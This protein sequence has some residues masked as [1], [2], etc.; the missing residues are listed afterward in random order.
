[1]SHSKPSILIADDDE[2]VLSALTLALK[3]ENYQIIKATTPHQVITLLSRKQFSCLL[4]DLNYTQDTTSGSEGMQLVEAIRNIDSHVP[5]IAMTGYSSVDIAVEMMKRGA[6]DFIEKPWRNAQLSN[7]IKQQIERVNIVRKNEK[8]SQANALLTNKQRGVIAHS[9]EMRQVLAQ[10]ERIAVS[11]M[12]VLFTGENGTGKSM[13]AHYL[14][15]HSTRNNNS[16]ITVNMGAISEPLF[17]SEMFGHVKGAFT[18]AKE[19]RIGRFELASQGTLFLD[20]IANIHLN[21]QAKLLHILE[22]RK[23][24]RVG[25]HI[26]LDADVRVVSATNA[27]LEQLVLEKQFRQD[28][29]YRLNTV[30]IRIP[31]LKERVDDIIPLAN[32]FIEQYCQKYRM[33]T[34]TLSKE[35][36]QAMMYYQW[37]GNIRELSHTIERALFLSPEQTIQ[38]ND[39]NLPTNKATISQCLH[40][41]TLEDIEK[42]IIIER[43]QR[44]QHDPHNTAKSLGLSR[45]SYYR[46]L[47]KYQL[48]NAQ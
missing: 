47:E 28:L 15:Q 6:N 42:Q 4:L 13:L 20:E 27:N 23:F 46:R 44:F 41:K 16:F 32:Y 25:S 24:E 29:L 18:D 7:K 21:Q 19:D 37:P 22:E 2:N 14:H 17:E 36:A 12:N 48:T 38:L 10:I 35:A 8:L 34:K 26:T 31:S 40:E 43:L 33:Q 5:I 39:L 11:D 3:N 45:S 9:A 30:E 1:M